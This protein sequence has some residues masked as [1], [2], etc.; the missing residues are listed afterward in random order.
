MKKLKENK[1]WKVKKCG[2]CDICHILTHF[3]N[4]MQRKK[5]G[6]CICKNCYLTKKYK[7]KYL[8][9]KIMNWG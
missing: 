2:N 1:Y 3:Q 8:H 4:G 7:I 5:D 9:V 6:L